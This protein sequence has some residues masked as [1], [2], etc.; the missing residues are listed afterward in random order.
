MS[1]N[2]ASYP[3][4]TALKFE[5]ANWVSGDALSRD[6]TPSQR[7]HEPKSRIDTIDPMNGE[8]ITDTRGH[9][10]LVDGNLTIYFANDATRKAY[11]ELPLNHPVPNLPFPAGNDDDR[12]G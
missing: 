10:S 3:S 5:S 6:R 1:T 4:A 7:L 12:G 9:P 8:N 11:I 2:T